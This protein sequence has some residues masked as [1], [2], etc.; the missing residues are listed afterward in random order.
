M[1]PAATLLCSVSPAAVGGTLTRQV[2]SVAATTVSPLPDAPEYCCS[3]AI[4]CQTGPASACICTPHGLRPCSAT[5]HSGFHRRLRLVPPSYCS[6][7]PYCPSPTAVLV[8][9]PWPRPCPLCDTFLA[10]KAQGITDNQRQK[11]YFNSRRL[12]DVMFPL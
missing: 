2:S 12:L 7:A 11:R 10:C 5:G 4:Y 3:P 6:S 1:P 9:P 8:L